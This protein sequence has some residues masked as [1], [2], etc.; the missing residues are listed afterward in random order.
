MINAVVVSNNFIISSF[1]NK[2]F[3]IRAAFFSMNAI[4]NYSYDIATFGS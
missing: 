3:I 2:L 4:T 1:S